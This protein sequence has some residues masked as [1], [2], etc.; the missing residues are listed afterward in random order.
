MPVDTLRSR[1]SKRTERALSKHKEKSPS[2]KN[3]DR[4]KKKLNR[5]PV[6]VSATIMSDCRK[7][8]GLP[9]CDS[10]ISKCSMRSLVIRCASCGQKVRVRIVDDGSEKYLCPVCIVHP[11]GAR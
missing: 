5:G 10:D 9:G 4:I 3:S 7:C 6:V 11:T 1:I 8:S 2:E